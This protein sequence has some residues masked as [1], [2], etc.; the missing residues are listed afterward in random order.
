M[1]GYP[2]LYNTPNMYQQPAPQNTDERIW[3]QNETSAEAYLVAPN[4]FV[5]LWDAS[6]PIFYE[7]HADSSGRPYPMEVYEYSR[8]VPKK[9]VKD[10]D[11]IN[12]Y[13]D[14]FKAIESRLK[15]IE[16]VLQ[17]DTESDGN[18]ATI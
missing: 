2:N 11:G 1:Y 14:K 10:D 12:A 9:A 5:R 3:V 15:A 13:E 8:R 6:Q 18:D 7:K 4:G 16:E 17:N